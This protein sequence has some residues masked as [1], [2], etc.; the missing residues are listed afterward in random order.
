MKVLMVA[1][2]SNP[3]IKVG[4]LGDVVFGLSKSYVEEGHDVSIIIPFYEKLKHDPKFNYTHA[5]SMEVYMGWR[6]FNIDVF[7]TT[8]QGV[9][10]YF[11][12]N[13]QY[14]IR[15]GIYGYSDD[16][17]RWAFFVHAVRQFIHHLQTK[18]SIIHVH[19]YHPG[20][21]ATVMKQ[22]DHHQ[23]WFNSM[24]FVFTLHSPAFQGELERGKLDDFY[25]LH[26]DLFDYGHLRLKDKVSTLKAAIMD[27]DYITTVSPTHAKELL[28]VEGSFGLDGVFNL[29]RHAFEGILNGI[30]EDEWNPYNDPMLPLQFLKDSFFETKAQNKASL[31]QSLG[32]QDHNRPLFGVVSRLTF[33]KGISLVIDH[34]ENLIHRGANVIVLGAGEW[35]LEHRLKHLEYM[36]PQ[37]LKVELGYNNPLAHRIYASSD[38]FFMPSLFEPCGISQMIALRFG[39]LPIVRATGGLKDTVIGHHQGNDKATG[40]V[41]DHYNHEAL[42]WAIDQAF[43][44]YHD[45]AIFNQLRKNAMSQKNSWVYAAKKYLNLYKKLQQ[46]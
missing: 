1:T 19:D 23:P 38:F 9:H 40:I 4:G 24:K 33:Q 14:F 17:E 46:S 29:R 43:Y 6:H 26:T 45:K 36:Y 41:F 39:T 16:G 37:H 11:V 28:T 20:M 10:F 7:Q 5:F 15:G 21:L 35:N 12:D 13:A 30:D 42:A 8:Y 3:Y 32:W 27:S 44:L 25:Q 34:I 2:E 22:K 18:P 31:Y